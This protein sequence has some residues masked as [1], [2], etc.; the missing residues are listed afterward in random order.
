MRISRDEAMKDLQA[1]EKDG[2]MGEDEV[3]RHQKEI[4]KM[5]DEVNKKLDESYTKKEKEILS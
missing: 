3:F 4:Q 1:K 2:G 5:V